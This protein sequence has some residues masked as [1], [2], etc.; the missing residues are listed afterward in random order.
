MTLL[1]LAFFPDACGNRFIRA[2]LGFLS[3]TPAMELSV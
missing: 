2:A 1:P 3:A